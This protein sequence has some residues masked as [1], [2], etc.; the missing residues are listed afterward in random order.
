MTDSTENT[1]LAAVHDFWMA[2]FGAVVAGSGLDQNSVAQAMLT[3]S[4]FQRLVATQDAE[5]IAADLVKFADWVR[6]CGQPVQQ[7]DEAPPTAMH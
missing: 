2:Q 4:V 5:R 1:N 7:M 6:R 3:V